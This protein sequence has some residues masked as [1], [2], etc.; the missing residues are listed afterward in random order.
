MDIGLDSSGVAGVPGS[1]PGPAVCFQ[2]M[3]MVIPPFLLHLVPWSVPGTDRLT[4]A[5]EKTWGDLRGRRS[6]KEGGM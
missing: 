2:C 1:I 5:K 4:P 6:F 3:Y